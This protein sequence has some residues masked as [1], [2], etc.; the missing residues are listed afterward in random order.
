MRIVEVI[1][2]GEQGGAQRHVAELV[3]YLARQGHEVRV[4]H[5]GGKWLTQ[6]V[7]GVADIYYLPH[8]RREISVRDVQTLWALGRLIGDLNPDVIHAHSSKA[9][10][11]CRLVGWQVKIPVVYTVHGFVFF[12]PTRSIWSRGLYRLLETW[13][14]RHSR[15][16]ITLSDLDM[17]F[18]QKAG[19]RAVVRK[20]PNGVSVRP[21][22]PRLPG[23]RRNIG[24]IG[25]FT[26]EKGLDVVTTA[27]A[28]T[29]GWRWLIAGDG[30]LS[31]DLERTRRQLSN[32]EWLGWVD[33]TEQFFRDVDIIVQPSYKEGLPYTVLDAMGWGLPV[34]ATP[35]GALPEIL[36]QVD[37]RLLCPVGDAQGLIKAV[38]F[39]F[40]NYGSLARACYELV[41][42]RY[43]LDIQ[44]KRT[45]E[46]LTLA[47]QA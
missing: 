32:V 17:E 1:T 9:G 5:G 46:T 7:D 47:V 36:G 40:D 37:R 19:T 43:D 3:T 27:A 21:E 11:L 4:I 15:G 2:G 6:A 30:G 8:L 41:K 20:I 14:A 35:V 22:G 24:F 29:P 42:V 33:D 34:V 31:R 18:A 12:D 44:L 25:R 23:A 16:I 28:M 38:A 13:G 45:I 26:A 39:V 10:I